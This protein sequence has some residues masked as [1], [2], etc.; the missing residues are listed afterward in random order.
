MIKYDQLHVAFSPNITI[1][2]KIWNKIRSPPKIVLTFKFELN[3][4]NVLPYYKNGIKVVIKD[5]FVF[6]L[7]R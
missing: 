4:K 6:V 7:H 2:L 1:T 3:K 5:D